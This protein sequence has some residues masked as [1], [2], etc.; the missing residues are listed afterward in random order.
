MAETSKAHDE[1]T[2]SKMY[3][4]SKNRVRQEKWKLLGV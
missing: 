2:E 3:D 4:K 1:Y